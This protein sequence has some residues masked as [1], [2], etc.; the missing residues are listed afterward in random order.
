MKIILTI[1]LIKNGEKIKTIIK[2]T[3]QQLT[4]KDE[5][6]KHKKNRWIDEECK[7]AIEETKKARG[8]WLI[9]G[10]KENEEKE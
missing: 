5:T 6:H 1:I 4:E 8:K 9:R 10:R 3:K 2:K 7:N